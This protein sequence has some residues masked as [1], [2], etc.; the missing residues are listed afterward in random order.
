MNLFNIITP[1]KGSTSFIPFRDEVIEHY[2]GD[3]KSKNDIKMINARSSHKWECKA[4]Y[5]INMKIDGN[6][7]KCNYNKGYDK[8]YNHVENKHKDYLN[9]LFNKRQSIQTIFECNSTKAKYIYG[10]LDNLC[11]NNLSFSDCSKAKHR[12]YS[13]LDPISRNS[14][15]KY[16]TALSKAIANEIKNSLP[17]NIGLIIDGWKGANGI[18]YCGIYGQYPKDDIKQRPLLAICP[19][20]YERD[21]GAASYYATL[22]STLEWYG[23]SCDNMLYLISDNCATMQCLSR[24]YLK[25]PFIGCYAHKMNLAVKRYLLVPERTICVKLRTV[26]LLKLYN[27]HHVMQKDYLVNQS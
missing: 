26:Q 13:S 20:V 1:A 19:L 3:I 4:C 18:F 10:H 8:L 2:F 7:V 24:D 17:T 23:L 27:P 5:S 6:I 14:L 12:L 16:H 21:H 11:S 25:C 22:N 9:V 15:I